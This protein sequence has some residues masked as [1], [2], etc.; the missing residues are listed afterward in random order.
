MIILVTGATGQQGG[1][2]A[3]HLLA[4]GWHVRALVRDPRSAAA[5]ALV[6]AGAELVVGDMGDRMSLD[7]AM[8]GA[9]GVFTVQPANTAPDFDDNEVAHGVAVAEAALAAGVRHLVYTSVGGADR[10]TGIAHWETK[11]TIERHIRAIGL[12]ATILRPVMFMENHLMPEYGLLGDSALVKVI[13]PGSR[14]Q[15]IAVDDIGAFAALA[16]GDPSYYLGKAIEIAGDEITRERLIEAARRTAG[17]FDLGALEGGT[18]EEGAAGGSFGGW[19]AD[20]PALRKLYPGLMN[21]DTWMEREGRAGFE[22]MF[23]LK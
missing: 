4:D 8:A 9:H 19:R 13:P 5:Q 11:W 21:F 22:A 17:G 16:F 1:A 10:A 6:Q 20:I 18:P 3:R 2:T 7:A 23:R 12:P 14:F 15:V